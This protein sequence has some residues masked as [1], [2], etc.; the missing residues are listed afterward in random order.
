M[1]VGVSKTNRK[2]NECGEE[3]ADQP[4]EGEAHKQNKG[5]LPMK[6]EYTSKKK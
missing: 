2:R 3:V 5:H 1:S 4:K 6:L